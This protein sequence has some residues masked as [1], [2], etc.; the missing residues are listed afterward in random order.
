MA[1]VVKDTRNLRDS[2]TST[3]IFLGI[4][5]GLYSLVTFLS[6]MARQDIVIRVK[7]PE[8]LCS[9]GSDSLPVDVQH[10]HPLLQLQ[11]YEAGLTQSFSLSGGNRSKVKKTEMRECEVQNKC[12][13]P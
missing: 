13:I 3:P 1:M 7:R 5:R 11:S 10:G 2:A 12:S 9:Q 8:R 6:G 4:L